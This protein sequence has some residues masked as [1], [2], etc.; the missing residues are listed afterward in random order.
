[1]NVNEHER[2][3][4]ITRRYK[5]KYRNIDFIAVLHFTVTVFN[6]EYDSYPKMRVTWPLAC[7]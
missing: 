5:I 1:M 6:N 2:L 7:C 4:N 3:S